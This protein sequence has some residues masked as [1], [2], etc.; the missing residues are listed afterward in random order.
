MVQK[1]TSFQNKHL[2]FKN[3]Y[4]QNGKLIDMAFLEEQVRD[5]VSNSIHLHTECPF[6][7]CH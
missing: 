2:K 1:I 6:S 4:R 3:V 5:E 7:L